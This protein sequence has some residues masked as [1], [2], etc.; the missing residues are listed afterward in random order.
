MQTATSLLFVGFKAREVAACGGVAKVVMV[1]NV[2]RS[3]NNI[4]SPDA[5]ITNESLFVGAKQ[6]TASSRFIALI[7]SH[8]WV[9]IVVE[10][11]L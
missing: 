4:F 1:L 11:L 3:N 10:E 9:V 5:D 6:G 7:S 2:D 8:S